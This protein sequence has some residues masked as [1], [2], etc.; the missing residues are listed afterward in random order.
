MFESFAPTT[1]HASTF[2]HSPGRDEKILD[3]LNVRGMSKLC[4][5]SQNIVISSAMKDASYLGS[6][7]VEKK[8][9]VG[10]AQH[11]VFVEHEFVPFWSS[12]ENK[13]KT[14]DD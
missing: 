7:D 11:M 10:D 4:S 5:G 9:K 13:I 12:D 3:G 8:L 14:K 2:D 1:W 6:F